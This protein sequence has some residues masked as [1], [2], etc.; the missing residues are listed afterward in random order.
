[1][2]TMEHEPRENA[3]DVVRFHLS[4][5]VD[6][7]ARSVEFF[8]LLFDVGPSKHLPD[9][10]KFEIDQPPLVLSLE[11]NRAARGGK[12]NHL[13]F[14]LAS[15]EALV[16]M[17]LRLELHGVRSQREDGVACCYARQTKFWIT[18]PDGNLWEMYTLEEDIE[19]R[20]GGHVPDVPQQVVE[21]GTAPALWAHRLGEAIPQRILAETAGADEVLLEGTFNAALPAAAKQAFLAEV[22]RVLKPGGRVSL[23]QLTARESLD[24]LSAPLSGPAAV[25]EAVPSA[26]QLVT[27]LA[28]AGFVD[29]YF[30]KLAEHASLLADGVECRET[31]LIGYK[32]AEKSSDAPH[33]VL[34][35]GPLPAIVDD[36]GRRF[37]RG[38]WTSVDDATRKQLR[39]G[40]LAQ[41][42][43][44]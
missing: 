31:R 37:V 21:L 32:P 4:L 22:A 24:T 42:F 39:S 40:P 30:E 15:S 3:T 10:A 41:Q 11:P 9:Y 8:S 7:L 6:D 36:A 34:Y 44:F 38:C 1:M 25:V 19:H 5:N 18:D 20:C 2:A 27:Q 33:Q 13:G 28:S 43:V 16:A 12:L 29:L 17:Q 23:Y 14:R 26:E 35:K